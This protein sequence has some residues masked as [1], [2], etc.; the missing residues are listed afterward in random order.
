M[1]NLNTKETGIFD[2][3]ITS[4]NNAAL[5]TN[6]KMNFKLRCNITYILRY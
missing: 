2:L 5:S 6:R 3:H 1:Q 4:H